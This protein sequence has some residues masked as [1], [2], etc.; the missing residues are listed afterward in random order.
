MSDNTVGNAVKLAGELV[1]TP[2]ASLLLDGNI[3]QGIGH[4]LA[5]LAAGVVLGPVGVVLVAANS[6][7]LSVSE[8]K[9]P[10]HKHFVSS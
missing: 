10:L 7:S 5:G 2:G 8:D 4:A 1:I 3:K 6:L 9:R